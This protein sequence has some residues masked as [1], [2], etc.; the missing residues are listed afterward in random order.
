[1]P[2]LD[3]QKMSKSYGNTITLREDAESGH[4]QAEAHADRSG[5]DSPHDPGDPAKC[6]VWQLHQVYS[7]ERLQAWVQKGAAAPGSAAW[8]ASSR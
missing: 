7:D 6:P 5:A 8:S 2:G 3:G 1:M 4:A